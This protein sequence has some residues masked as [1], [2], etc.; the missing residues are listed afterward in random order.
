LY[1]ILAILIF[2]VLIFV[3]ELGHFL[4]AKLFGVRVNE[5]SMCMGPAIFKKTVGETTY[6]LRC[7]PIGG[8]CAMEGE[9]EDS[10]DPR[11]FTSKPAWQRAI[12]LVAGAAMNFLT[13]LLILFFLYLPS[14]GFVT[15]EIVDFM[16]GCVL[17]SETGLQAGDQI[18]SVDSEN[19][20]VSS[21]LTM[22][23]QR[24]KDTRY[25]LVIR[26]DGQ[27]IKLKDFKMEPQAFEV[28]GETK[29][30]YGLYFGTVE[31]NLWQT[32]KYSWNSAI[33]FGRMVKM[34]LVDLVTGAV[35]LKDMSGPVGIVAMI[36]ETGSAA[37]STSEGVLDTLYLGAFLAVNLA[38]M[39]LLPIPALDGGRV[40][41]LIL[42]GL[43]ER[44]TRRKLNAK[45]EGYVHAVGMIFLLG[46][47]AVLIFKDVF[48]LFQ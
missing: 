11:A 33:N 17:N 20:Y 30:M 46:L 48:M 18:L 36:S 25:D 45:Y 47:S 38:F 3:H 39:N 12:I 40:L 29:M 42:T 26:R 1:I 19:V 41:A 13:G 5:F 4:T 27:R 15:T 8:Y 24:G 32:L 31:N 37:E 10:E 35:G 34:G 21:D 22:L 9:D 43:I 7:I 2:G 44:I 16:P 23:L 6:S 28:D 14:E